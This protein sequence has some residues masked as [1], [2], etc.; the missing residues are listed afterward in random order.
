MKSK[1]LSFT[2]ASLC[3]MSTAFAPVPGRSDSN[4]AIP[5][6]SGHGPLNVVQVVPGSVI[7]ETWGGYV[8]TGQDFT[9]AKGSWN[10]H[11]LDCSVTPNA[12]A[13]IWVGID[14]YMDTTVEQ[15][16]ITAQCES[17]TPS[18]SAWY[19]LYPAPPVAIDMIIAPDDLI[20]ASVSYSDGKF[21]LGLHN[22]T[23]GAEF[24]IVKPDSGTQR[25]SAEWIVSG[26]PCTG[27]PLSDF[28]VLEFGKDYT[29]DAGTNYATDNTVNDAPIADFG[30]S[31]LKITMG[32]TGVDWAVPTKLTTDGTSFKVNWK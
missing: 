24:Q 31:A 22:R 7:S 5:P 9:F 29:S 16:G 28:S 3:A 25:T 19:D 1:A 4:A 30:S 21:T 27:L 32:C 6:Q 12:L 20:G 13:E 2:L 14:G 8:V 10:I 26:T 18:Y 17:V 11:E 23:T 15:I